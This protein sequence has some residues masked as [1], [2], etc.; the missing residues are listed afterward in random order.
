MIRK[1][2]S[3]TAARLLIASA[4]LGI[5]WLAARTLGAEGMGTISLFILGISIIQMISAMVGGSALVYLVP[6]YPV[7]QLLLP[8]WLWAVFVSLSG[9]YL[10]CLFGLIPGELTPA[11]AAVSLLQS[12]FSINQNIQLGQEKVLQY[13]IAAVLQTVTVL[14]TLIILFEIFRQQ[15]IQSYITALF[16]SYSLGILLSFTGI[17]RGKERVKRWNPELFRE[18][19]RFGGY[20]QAASFMQLFNY[21]LSY[22]IIEKSFDRAT[23][24]V[25][26]I[27]VQIS[28]SVWI[29]SKSIALVQYARISNSKDSLYT[30]NLTLGFIKFTALFTTLIAGILLMLPSEFFVLIFQ[31]DFSNVNKVILSLSAGIIAVAV[32]L[33]FSH[34]F[35]GSGK[36]WHNTVSS[37]IGLI[38]TIIL[39]FTLIP[40]MGI[41]GAGI[42]AS[43]SYTAGMTY[44]LLIF[45]KVA[46]CKWQDF[47][48]KKEDIMQVADILRG[49]T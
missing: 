46:E 3:T 19:F 42:T 34:Y 29:I 14:I 49:R 25:F 48:I 22:Y 37:G 18:I 32:S 36:P 26:S 12:L 10:L 20:L 35:S 40:A 21:R 9:S 1:I 2:L 4:N 17:T 8:S 33:M 7:V 15:T 5:V 47:L 27:G 24:G 28:E 38:F 31:S 45:K 44:Q 13:N 16:I 23:L 30:R 6:R 43:V 11:L 39:G 41:T